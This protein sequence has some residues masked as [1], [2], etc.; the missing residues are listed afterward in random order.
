MKAIV[1]D[2]YGPAEML[3]LADIEPPEISDG[4]VLVR[5]RAAGVDPGVWH[6]MTG[7]PYLVRVMG[8]GLRAPMSRIPGFDVAGR[9]EAVGAK[10]TRFSP[11]D[12]VFGMCRGSF[13]ELAS[14]REDRLAAKPPSLSFEE[15]A[16]VPTSALTALQGLRDQGKV[17]AGQRVLIIGAAGGVGHFAVQLAKALGAEVTGVASTTKLELVRSIGADH[18]IDYTREDVTTQGPRYDV[19]LD[20]AG[21]RPVSRLR[22]ALTARGTLVITGAEGGNRVTGGIGRQIGAAMLS[23]FVRHNLRVY[24]A[25]ANQPDLRYLS[26][27]LDDGTITPVIDRTY[28][29]AEAAGALHHLE[30][31]HARG[32]IVL[33]V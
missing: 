29:L 28:P 30:Q 15:A 3:E 27:L 10:V 33:T 6:L 8:F 22:R 23:P 24:I 2:R 16:A 5:V 32:K 18:V 7:L 26:E 25:H 20:T 31:G 13:A 4:E 17:A 19:I 11:G 9:V 21:A 1:H 12:E 14:A